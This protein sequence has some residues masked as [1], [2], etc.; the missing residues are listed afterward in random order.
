VGIDSMAKTRAPQTSMMKER[1]AVA[2]V[3]ITGLLFV[4]IILALVL[5]ILRTIY[6]TEINA[7]WFGA[8]ESSGIPVPLYYVV[9]VPLS[10]ILIWWRFKK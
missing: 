1:Y 8:L 4:A 5:P 10:A 6:A 7:W 9:A 3:V 2:P